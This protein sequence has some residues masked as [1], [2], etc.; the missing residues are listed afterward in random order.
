MKRSDQPGAPSL[1]IDT[2]DEEETHDEAVQPETYDEG[3]GL[4]PDSSTKEDHAA[5]LPTKP[6]RSTS[7]VAEDVIERKGQY[8]RFAESWFSKKGWTTEKRR[9]QGMSIDG[10]ERLETPND[11]ATGLN[12]PRPQSPLVA[13]TFDG[14]ESRDRTKDLERPN[15]ALETDMSGS[16][17][18]NVTNKLLR[19]TRMLLESRSFFFS[20]ELDITRRLGTHDN[21]T[22]VM[23]LHKFADPLVSRSFQ[24]LLDSFTDLWSILVLL[25]PTSSATVHRQWTSVSKFLCN[26]SELILKLSGTA[27]CG[28]KTLM[29]SCS[30]PGIQSRP[31][32][33]LLTRRILVNLY[34]L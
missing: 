9:T 10:V 29:T 25:E 28:S 23:P 6:A 26:S 21:K 8:G 17:P 30:F 5:I 7:S 33:N 1:D 24:Y 18:A 31:P 27:C 20:Y 11:Q 22:F 14:F 15:Q 16:P 12:D 32:K 2:S 13:T 4:S 19:T 34:C 3:S